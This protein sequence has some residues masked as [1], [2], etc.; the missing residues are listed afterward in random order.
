[1]K[2]RVF[3]KN[4]FGSVSIMTNFMTRR[5]CEKFCLGR[6]GHIPPFAYITTCK[7]RNSFRRVYGD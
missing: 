2:Y 5:M 1:M 4:Y 3:T 7:D 6:W